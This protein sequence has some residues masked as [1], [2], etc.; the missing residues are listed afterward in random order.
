MAI[1]NGAA[2]RDALL[3]MLEKRMGM[4]STYHSKNRAGENRACEHTQMV[5]CSVLSERAHLDESISTKLLGNP[6][7]HLLQCATCPFL[8]NAGRTEASL[9]M[10]EFEFKSR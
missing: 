3:N 1:E 5:G 10:F 7:R 9:D 8:F 4:V 6:A 2:I